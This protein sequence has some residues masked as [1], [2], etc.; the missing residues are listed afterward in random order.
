LL[1][2]KGM[3]EGGAGGGGVPH[4]KKTPLRERI[5]RLLYCASCTVPD[6]LL[7]CAMCPGFV[8]TSRAKAVANAGLAAFIRAAGSTALRTYR[9]RHC[10]EK[11]LGKKTWTNTGFPIILVCNWGLQDPVL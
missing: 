7:Y 6:L 9:Q 3:G 4:N 11:D 5:L 1:R 10:A 2:K 8:I